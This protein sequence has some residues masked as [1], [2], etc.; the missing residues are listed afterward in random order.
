MNTSTKAMIGLGLIAVMV[1]YQI[2]SQLPTNVMLNDEINTMIVQVNEAF[3]KAE[4]EVLGVK[5]NPNPEPNAPKVPDPDPSKCI[6][7]GTGEIVQGDGHITQCPYHGSTEQE[8]ESNVQYVEP[9]A[10]I[11]VYPKRRG[12][13]ERLFFN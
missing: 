5:P 11:Y 3:D 7:G 1:F 4:V 8:P 6:C 12:F 9:N 2:K 10:K 13:L